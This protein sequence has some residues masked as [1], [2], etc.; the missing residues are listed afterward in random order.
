MYE[1][2]QYDIGLIPSDLQLLTISKK[3]LDYG[4][5]Q[6]KKEMVLIGLVLC[7][8]FLT[9]FSGSLT[10]QSTSTPVIRTITYSLTPTLIFNPESVVT[11]TPEPP[12]R[13]PIPLKGRAPDPTFL[14]V[15]PSSD[16]TVEVETILEY[17]NNYGPL[18]LREHNKYVLYKDLTND[19]VPEVGITSKFSLPEYFYIF[20]CKDGKYKTIFEQT[21]FICVY[22]IEDIQDGNRNGIPEILTAEISLAPASPLTYK[23]YEWDGVT[24]KNRFV[25]YFPDRPDTGEVELEGVGYEIKFINSATNSLKEIFTK[26]GYPIWSIMDGDLPWRKE[27]KWYRWDGQFYSLAKRTL[28]PPQYRFQAVQDADTL[29][30]DGDFDQALTM[31]QRVISDNSLLGWSADRKKYE[32]DLWLF[33]NFG[34]KKELIPTPPPDDPNERLN[35]TSYAKFRILWIHLKTKKLDL[36]RKDYESI[37]RDLVN[38]ESVEPF[39]E[40]A[41]LLWNGYDQ[42]HS[43]DEACKNVQTYANINTEDVFRYLKTSIGLGYLDI[44]MEYSPDVICPIMSTQ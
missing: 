38:F 13:C 41:K 7:I 21:S 1:T 17:L 18:P 22:S 20:T 39:V 37:T 23:L 4:A 19:G 29:V 6:L 43:I 28:D 25:P 5:N 9:G 14:D 40:L 35:L 12:A 15:E 33:N 36:A 31:Y 30:L 11:Y 32:K 24:F 2:C 44:Y 16:Q 10:T 27:N 26:N 3:C 8:L 42:T 34:N